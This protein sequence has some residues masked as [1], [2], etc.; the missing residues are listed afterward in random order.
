MMSLNG[1]IERLISVYQSASTVKSGR[2]YTTVNELADQIPATRPDTLKAAMDSLLYLGPILADKILTEEDKGALLAGLVS[3]AAMKPLAMARWYS[4][5]IPSKDS[6]VVPIDME[7]AKG[8]LLVNGIR[9][10]DKLAIVDDTLSTGGTAVSLI[11][12]AMAAGA[13]VVEMRVVTEKIGFGGR[14]RLMEEC[15]LDV[16]SV[17]GISINEKGVIKVEQVFGKPLETLG[18]LGGLRCVASE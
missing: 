15:G 9:R 5:P 7:Y 11:K 13:T 18:N 10:G 2:H 17:L 1:A 3:V 12:A 4:Y 8:Q 6:V 16:K 14:Q